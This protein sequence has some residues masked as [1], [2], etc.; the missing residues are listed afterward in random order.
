MWTLEIHSIVK[1]TLNNG[2]EKQGGPEILGAPI[3]SLYRG[4]LFQ[5]HSERWVAIGELKNKYLRDLK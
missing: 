3:P 4:R 1:G 2:E 5:I